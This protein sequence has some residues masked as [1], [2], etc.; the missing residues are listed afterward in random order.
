M[1]QAIQT[2]G[3]STIPEEDS[4]EP[5]APSVDTDCTV[6]SMATCATKACFGSNSC[7]L[8]ALKREPLE[9]QIDS[10]IDP[11]Q[12]PAEQLAD[13]SVDFVRPQRNSTADG[14]NKETTQSISSQ[15][16]S[17][18]RYQEPTPISKPIGPTEAVAKP[19]QKEATTTQSIQVMT[20]IPT[21]IPDAPNPK[22][23]TKTATLAEAKQTPL[24]DAASTADSAL[25]KPQPIDAPVL[26]NSKIIKPAPS[27]SIS[28]DKKDTATD[29]L[30]TG[31]EEPQITST[32]ASTTRPQ[33]E[34]KASLSHD[35]PKHQPIAS[36]VEQPTVSSADFNPQIKTQPTVEPALHGELSPEAMPELVA[37][38][39][40]DITNLSSKPLDI[41]TTSATAP[42]FHP[43]DTDILSISSQPES[44][45][46]TI[47]TTA[48]PDELQLAPDSSPTLENPIKNF[49]PN[50]DQILALPPTVDRIINQPVEAEP[51]FIVD[52]D[53]GVRSVKPPVE[54][55]E[56]IA[57]GIETLNFET[58]EEPATTLVIAAIQPEMT[59]LSV[60]DD[61]EITTEHPTELRYPHNWAKDKTTIE[62]SS[63]QP[64]LGTYGENIVE[65][66]PT[67][68]DDETGLADPHT[69]EDSGDPEQ[70]I[71]HPSV[72]TPLQVLVNHALG[73][74]AYTLAA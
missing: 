24:A 60:T 15:P 21:E 35:E 49:E 25:E 51:N 31:Q 6:A 62:P 40:P 64:S 12:S 74:V 69:V 70:P 29:R 10:R 41:T 30:T 42:D 34:A 22:L 26:N 66:E 5:I 46:A 20:P 9:F 32:D 44:G 57:G 7:P 56:P 67:P 50:V 54:Y 48:S 11:T 61:I 28:I 2:P 18:G 53:D 23:A 36:G 45:A 38:T 19:E 14:A 59:E 47:I 3:E 13:D 63:I 1:E 33:L 58:C 4:Y 71:Q 65:P 43:L 27:M 55:T 39:E 52:M 8:M 16:P 17:G 37:A 68:T 73:R 72:C